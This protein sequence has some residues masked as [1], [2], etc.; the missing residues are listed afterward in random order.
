MK[1]QVS[2]IIYQ[3]R[4]FFSR[5]GLKGVS[6]PY[7]TKGVTGPLS[8]LLSGLLLAHCGPEVK[9]EQ[10]LHPKPTPQKVFEDGTDDSYLFKNHNNRYEI[11][12]HKQEY[13]NT[14]QA[15]GTVAI[16][17]SDHMRL[18]DHN[19]FLQN[20]YAGKIK[21]H[22]DG[23]LKSK[24]EGAV[25]FDLGSA[26]LWKQGA[27]TVRTINNDKEVRPHLSTVVASDINNP[28]SP[29]TM[30]IDIFRKRGKKLPFPVE[31]I[32]MSITE[33]AQF[34]Q[35]LG[36]YLTRKDMPVILR[37]VNTGIDYYYSEENLR[38]HF[39]AAMNYL[40]GRNVLY[41]FNRFILYKGQRARRFQILGEIDPLFEA[42]NYGWKW[43]KINWKTRTLLDGFQP[44]TTYLPELKKK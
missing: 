14:K 42:E 33:P 23:N 19:I 4:V 16:Q 31:E 40:E 41:L 2:S 11:F 12:K 15:A 29:K 9:K 1:K 36:K 5:A 25:F 35:F 21:H 44:N 28:E 24:F 8:L 13:Y 26:I 18:Y 38:K 22:R 30:F 17:F 6:R 3:S 32:P 7:Q 39:V 34:Q 10:W 27:V 37:T 20:L 43:Q